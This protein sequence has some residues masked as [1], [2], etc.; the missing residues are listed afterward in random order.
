MQKSK[1]QPK[2]LPKQ[3]PK[4]PLKQQ[5]KQKY[6]QQQQPQ[7]AFVLP[8]FPFPKLKWVTT[9]QHNNNIYYL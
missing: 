2:H 6:K 5:P 3:L 7:S 9:R 4:Q 1:Q 8:F